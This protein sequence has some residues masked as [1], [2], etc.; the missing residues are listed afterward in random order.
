LRNV[1]CDSS[2]RSEIRALV[3]ASFLGLLGR[4]GQAQCF[5][6]ADKHRVAVR[7]RRV[8]L[9]PGGRFSGESVKVEL[10]L[11]GLVLGLLEVGRD[12]FVYESLQVVD[13]EG[14]PVINPRDNV[15]ID[16][17]L[18]DGLEHLEKFPREG[19]LGRRQVG[20]LGKAGQGE[21]ANVHSRLP[22]MVD[23]VVDV[24]VAVA[25]AVV[26]VVIIVIVI[27]DVVVITFISRFGWQYDFDR[28]AMEGILSSAGRL[29][30]KHCI[31]WK[32]L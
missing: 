24:A 9:F 7:A 23:F 15:G 3:A 19:Q 32:T 29:P 5:L 20:I 17:V 8:P 1:V 22:S 2:G 18:V 13:F 11:K 30:K 4:H 6:S 31:V 12:D 27:A 25:V 21:R 28:I 14:I 26:I 16:L 10:A